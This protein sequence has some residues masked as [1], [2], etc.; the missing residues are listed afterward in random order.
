MGDALLPAKASCQATWTRLFSAAHEHD[1][2]GQLEEA[3]ES[4]GRLNDQ[5]QEDMGTLATS[6]EEHVRS[7]AHPFPRLF[8]ALRS[9]LHTQAAVNQL[10]SL[11]AARLQVW[12]HRQTC[13]PGFRRHLMWLPVR[14]SRPVRWT[15][16]R[17]QRWLRSATVRAPHRTRAACATGSPGVVVSR[18]SSSGYSGLAVLPCSRRRCRRTLA[19]RESGNQ[20]CVSRCSAHSTPA[21]RARHGRPNSP[22]FVMYGCQRTSCNVTYASQSHK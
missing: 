7:T 2:W 10:L 12:V 11:L 20:P 4:Y 1:T 8:C 17:H 3:K 14:R 19:H 5:V 15:A 6:K 9:V 13:V 16:S 22:L 18:Q 21:P